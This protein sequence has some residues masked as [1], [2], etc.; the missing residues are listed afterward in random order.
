MET[1]QD[2]RNIRAQF[3][4]RKSYAICEFLPLNQKI[5]SQSEN[6]KKAVNNI[7]VQNRNV[8][9][10]HENIKILQ[11]E[12]LQKNEIIKSLMKIQST[13]FNSMS[14]AKTNQTMWEQRDSN[15]EPPI[16]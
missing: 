15:S 9:L 10:F 8:D 7:N 12:L 2:I 4:V 16:S 1:Q 5:S 6:L 11:N 3:S 13:V 14:T